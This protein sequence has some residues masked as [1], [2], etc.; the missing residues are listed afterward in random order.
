[1]KRILCSMTLLALVMATAAPALAVTTEELDADPGAWDGREVSVEGELVGD[2]GRREDSV[3]VQLN[4]DPYAR[5]PLLEGGEPAGANRGIAVRI[6][7]PLFE[8]ALRDDAPGGYRWRG[9][10][11]RV[12]GIFKYHDPARSGETYLEASAL[13]VLEPGREL[14]EANRAWAA[15]AGAVLLLA[16]AAVLIDR[17]RQRTETLH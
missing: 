10:L 8:A 1:M 5:R 2:F 3:W 4:D 16:T 14:P 9:P 17:R 13:D 7:R 11:V 15:W 12:T 6:P